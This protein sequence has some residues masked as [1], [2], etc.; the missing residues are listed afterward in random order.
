MHTQNI[1][2]RVKVF[3]FVFSCFTVLTLLSAPSDLLSPSLLSSSL[4][5]PCLL[6]PPS[7]RLEALRSNSTIAIVQFISVYFASII[8]FIIDSHIRRWKR[9]SRRQRQLNSATELTGKR[10]ITIEETR[11]NRIFHLTW[12]H[13]PESIFFS[14]STSAPFS[15]LSLSLFL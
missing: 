12:L 11:F 5:P 2:W 3:P 7:L 8:G 15:A 6:L 9:E 4:S 14:Q 10:R 1:R 13:F